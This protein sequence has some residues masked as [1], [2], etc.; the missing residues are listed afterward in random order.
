LTEALQ[1]NR[2]LWEFKMEFYAKLFA[3]ILPHLREYMVLYIVGIPILI[4]IIVLTHRYSV[5]MII[6]L[7]QIVIYNLIMHGIIHVAVPVFAWFKN[8]SAMKMVKAPDDFVH[9]ETPLRRFWDMESYDP[10]WIIWL[11][12]VL[13]VVIFLLVYYFRPLKPQYKHKSRYQQ[14]AEKKT[15]VKD[16][17][18]WGVPKKYK[19]TSSS[20][21]T[22]KNNT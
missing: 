18:G 10:S 4:G 11:E 3:P 9:W 16:D 5:P 12:V 1:G 17:D 21:H 8:S 15:V 13:S 22:W 6:F 14:A 20:S 7:L 19:T 2:S